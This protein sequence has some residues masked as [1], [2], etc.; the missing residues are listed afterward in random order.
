MLS[1]HPTIHTSPTT[2]RAFVLKEYGGPAAAEI[3]EVPQPSPAAGEILVRVQAAGLNPVD[4]KFR[5]GKLKVVYRPKLP[6]IMG[7]EL[8]GTVAARGA[9][10]TE[11]TD[12][13]RV[14]A[15]CDNARMGAFAEYSCV[16]AAVA[17]KIPDTLDYTA[18]AGLPLAGLTA[19]Q[20]L[21]DELHVKPGERIFI[22]A[23]AGGVGT[24]AIQ[25]A[26]HLGAIVATTASP[27]GESL[28][29][30]LG[31][32][33]VIDYTRQQFDQELRDLDGAMDLIGGDTLRRTLAIVKRGGMVVSI[34]GVPEPATARQDLGRGAGLAALFWLISLSIRARARRYRVRYRY[35]FMHA[36][37]SELAE[38]ARM[39]EAGTIKPVID[40]MYP[41]SAIHEAF[42]Y[43]E[44][45]HA[46]G[47]VIVRIDE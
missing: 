42:A 41:F 20:C 33:Q 44:E 24:F 46:K 47:K 34:A 7:N 23:G 40:R 37:G 30:S 19:L 18:A 43:L 11:F 5:Q 2:M 38:L 12:G 31:A 15:R 4:Y 10:V 26:K 22:S 35:L 13:D 8:A 28:V 32:D 1:V 25:I 14:F 6:L 39:I 36:S 45:G 9:G 3:R 27:R 21:R 16:K 29:R 17:T